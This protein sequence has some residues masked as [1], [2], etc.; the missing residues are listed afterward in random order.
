MEKELKAGESIVGGGTT[1]SLVSRLGI[2]GFGQVFLAESGGE[3]VALKVVDTAGWSENEYRVF[4]GLIVSEAAFLSNLSHPRLP[5][6]KAFF[7]S[8]SRYFLAM[9]WVKGQTLEQLVKM[10][11]PLEYREVLQLLSCLLDLL[12]HLHCD[13]QPAV[14]FGDLKPSN[15][16]RTYDGTYRCVDLGLVTQVGARLNRRF[17]VFSPN[18]SAPERALPGKAT[19][20]QDVFSL[21]ATLYFAILGEVPSEHSHEAETKARIQKTLSISSSGRYDSHGVSDLATLLVAGLI[22]EVSA[23]PS[24]LKPYSKFMTRCQ[25]HA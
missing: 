19:E 21:C 13:C 8:G 1:W 4:N 10:E 16:L 2:G 12:T 18:Y 24:S 22:P 11:G 15:L 14:V 17:A 6:L 5:K 7:A 23:R 25:G 20:A 9:D 3:L